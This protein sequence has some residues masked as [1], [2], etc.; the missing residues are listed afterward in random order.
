MG[1][2]GLLY[3]LHKQELW[4][5]LLHSVGEVAV[6]VLWLADTRMLQFCDVES[7]G[8]ESKHGQFES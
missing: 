1:V 2:D 3:Q 7:G 6:E 8:C 4:Q 5:H